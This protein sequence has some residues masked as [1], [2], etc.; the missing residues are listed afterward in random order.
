MSLTLRGRVVLM[1]VPVLALL[2][3]LGSAGLVLLSRLGGRIDAILREN[4]DSVVAMQGLR[5]ALERIDASFA[6]ALAGSE[7]LARDHFD[8]SW[9]PYEEYL[10]QEENLITLPGEGELVSRLRALTKAY[11]SAGGAFFALPPGDA[12]RHAAYYGAGGLLDQYRRVR[13][14]AGEILAI[15]QDLSLRRM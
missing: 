7:G 6:F 4:Y 10:R 14:V 13:D 3:I 2:I 8:P 5:E 1:L 12:R 9:K 15:N 11:R